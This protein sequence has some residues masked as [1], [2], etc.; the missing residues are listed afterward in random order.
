[1]P[2]TERHGAERLGVDRRRFLASGGSALAALLA[3]AC[4][5]RGPRAAQGALDYARQKNESLE[6]ALFRHVDGYAAQLRPGCW[7]PL[8]IVLHLRRGS[9]MGHSGP[10]RVDAGGRRHGA[11]T[12]ATEH[13]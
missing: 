9:G 1:M 6:A 11:A 8:S 2:P 5:S 4:D 12:V 10:R 3:I 7:Q 13:R